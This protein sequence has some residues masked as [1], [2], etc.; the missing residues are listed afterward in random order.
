MRILLVEDEPGTAI[1]MQTAL[2]QYGDCQLAVNG[3]AALQAYRLAWE[4]LLP[5]Q[6]ICLDVVM[7]QMDGHQALR[8]IRAYEAD[9]GI[10]PGQR[11]K[12]IMTSALGDPE[13]IASALEPGRAD[14]YMVKPVTLTKLSEQLERLG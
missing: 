5:Y 1:L 12:I 6:L 3:S 4:E 13:T 11:A 14:A 8:L 2:S 7:P 10:S 9:Q